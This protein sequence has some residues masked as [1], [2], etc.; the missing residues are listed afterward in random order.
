[1]VKRKFVAA[2]S[3]QLWVAD[4]TYV[5]T[6]AGWVYAA[7]VIDVFFGQSPSATMSD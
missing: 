4:L 3:N 1:M 7:F 2:A 5:R 6:F